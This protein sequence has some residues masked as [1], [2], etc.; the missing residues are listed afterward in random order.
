[1]VE[2]ANE[3]YCIPRVSLSCEPIVLQDSESEKKYNEEKHL[4]S[5]HKKDCWPS[6]LHLG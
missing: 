4:L 6:N 3:I 5:D 1:M 2:S